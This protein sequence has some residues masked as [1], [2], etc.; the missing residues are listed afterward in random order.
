[1]QKDINYEPSI[2]RVEQ[3]LPDG[4]VVNRKWLKEKGYE[5]TAIDYYVRSGK[6]VSIGRGVYRRPGPP[7]KWEH[8]FYSLQE[9]EYLLHV[10]GQSALDYQGYTHYLPLGNMQKEI[11]LYGKS[12]L[13]LWMKN[14][15]KNV[16]FTAYAQ[17]GFTKL[18]KNSLTTIVFGHWDW[19]LNLSSVELALFELLSQVKDESDF[20]VVDKYFESAT[21]LRTE[22]LNELLDASTNIQTKRLF[23]WFADRHSHQWNSKLNRDNI[24]LGSGKRSIIKGGAFDKKYNITVPKEML[25]NEEFF[26]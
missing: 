8:L 17:K 12:K 26:F 3:T 23:M 9:L 1:M 10:G 24:N 5:R 2:H 19:E 22:L 13:P 6:L 4:Q 7:L 14:I 11:T 16:K 21:V 18:P 15:D 25:N 20:L